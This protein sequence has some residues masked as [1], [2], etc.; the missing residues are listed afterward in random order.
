MIVSFFAPQPANAQFGFLL[1]LINIVTSGMNTLNNVMTSVNN[2]LRNVIGPIL[3]QINSIMT[4]AQ[5]I[6]GAIF[7]FQR[8]VIYPQQAIDRARALVGQ[9]QGIYAAI[10]GIWNVIVRS[11]TL[12]NP[13]QLESVLLSRDAGQIGSVGGNFSAVYT[14]L[15]AATEAHPAQ[16]DLID[17]SD[18]AAQAAMKRAIAIDA[19]ADQELAAAEQM[20][21]ALQSTAPGTAEMI[22]AQAGA[23]LVRSNAYTQQA[24]A[25]LMRIRTIEL[26]AQSARMKESARFTRETRNKLTELNK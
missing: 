8:N 5:Q 2:A 23:W 11:A 22:G 24:L 10:R 13:R 18:A 20:M 9:V 16:R 25:E 26:A 17:S 15:P 4:A 7:D 14:P 12:P 19:I 21:T 3:Q 1:G 6:M